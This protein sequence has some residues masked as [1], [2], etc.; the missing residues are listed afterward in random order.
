MVGDSS[1][2]S[3][4]SLIGDIEAHFKD[5]IIIEN[6]RI[7]GNILL[8]SGQ[9]HMIQYSIINCGRLHCIQTNLHLENVLMEATI[10]FNEDSIAIILDDCVPI[11]IKDCIRIN[12]IRICN[13]NIGIKCD[14][15]MFDARDV[16]GENV[17]IGCEFGTI[18]TTSASSTAGGLFTCFNVNPAIIYYKADDGNNLIRKGF[19]VKAKII[20]TLPN[21]SKVFRYIKHLELL[22]IKLDEP[23]EYD[24]MNQ[25][26][27][28][29][30]VKQLMYVSLDNCNI[31]ELRSENSVYDYDY[32]Y[33][34]Y[35]KNCDNIID[36]GFNCLKLDVGGSCVIGKHFRTLSKA[37]N[38]ISSE[39]STDVFV[40]RL[41]NNYINE[42]SN[43]VKLCKNLNVVCNIGERG[44]IKL[45]LDVRMYLESN[46][47]F[48]NIE[49]VGG[50]IVLDRLVN[51]EFIKCK[52]T[53]CII[54]CNASQLS[55][56]NCIINMTYDNDELEAPLFIGND[57]N[58]G[59][60]VNKIILRN[61]DII[62]QFKEL[63][64]IVGGYCIDSTSNSDDY[65]GID[66]IF[67][68][69]GCV[70]NRE[71]YLNSKIKSN[72]MGCVID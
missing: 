9:N 35:V 17:N 45:M 42:E 5:N 47:K 43:D 18:C 3:N 31:G 71:I 39:V 38:Y 26:V 61:V 65:C 69:I 8:E 15:S 36:I 20:I 25:G 52:F 6:V 10:V 44:I 62:L 59:N 1:M 51:C 19:M 64:P 41:V 37:L 27:I 30:T 53:N 23:I 40:I 29:V 63:S 34:V 66:D 28:S 50:C 33:D 4:I 7:T 49:F 46:N 2:I 55:M 16:I 70:F 21:G 60:L 14:M 54:K 56:T 57:G 32:D 11:N 24:W 48:E 72:I 58:D 13:Y 67:I 22:V 68:A 12:N